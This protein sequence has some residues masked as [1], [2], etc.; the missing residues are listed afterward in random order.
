M[1]SR[2][3][4]SGVFCACVFLLPSLSA[5]TFRPPGFSFSRSERC[6]GGPSANRL[7]RLTCKSL[8]LLT[9]RST[10]CAWTFLLPLHLLEKLDKQGYK[11]DPA[12]AKQDLWI[13]LPTPIKD[14]L[15]NPTPTFPKTVTPTTPTR[16]SRLQ[17][18]K[19][20]A[21]DSDSG[22]G[23]GGIGMGISMSNYEATTI[24][25]PDTASDPRVDAIAASLGI[26][27]NAATQAAL[28][29]RLEA[30][31]RKI[32]LRKMIEDS[33]KQLRASNHQRPSRGISL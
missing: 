2:H 20:T 24:K 31:T 25:P 10:S 4:V 30:E 7:G 26:T 18:K 9:G 15:E 12:R 23:G 22:G 11:N 19:D 28:R 8:K 32:K 29:A 13:Q 14:A 16:L 6:V 17:D 21:T 1:A 33:K 5:G 3:A 27:L